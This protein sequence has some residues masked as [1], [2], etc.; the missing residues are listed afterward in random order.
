MSVPPQQYAEIIEPGY[1]ALQLDTV[2]EK[3][4]E[5]DLGFT[6]VIEKGVLQILG[7]F[8]R[9]LPFSFLLIGRAMLLDIFSPGGAATR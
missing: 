9:H 2:H 6:D 8:R 5:R 1:D 7:S 3:N 4:R